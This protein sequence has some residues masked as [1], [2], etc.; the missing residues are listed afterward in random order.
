MSV[1]G[2]ISDVPAGR[3]LF[4]IVANPKEPPH[5]V[6]LTSYNPCCRRVVSPQSG[7]SPVGAVDESTCEKDMLCGGIGIHMG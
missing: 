4:T 6:D 7:L 2:S 1:R 3:R 5:R